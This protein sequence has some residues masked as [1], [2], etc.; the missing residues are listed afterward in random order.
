VCALTQ[1]QL[2]CLQSKKHKIN[3]ITTHFPGEN[4]RNG[5]RGGGGGIIKIWGEFK[6]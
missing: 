6:K 1:I 5:R 3:K 2:L 4:R